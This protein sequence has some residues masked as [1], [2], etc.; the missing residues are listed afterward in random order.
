MD[1][2]FTRLIAKIL[3]RSLHYN[4]AGFEEREDEDYHHL[5]HLEYKIKL[6][7]NPREDDHQQLERLIA[8]MTAIIGTRTKE[9]D[10]E[11]ET[12]HKAVTALARD[13][14]KREW[15]RVKDRIYPP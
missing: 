5:T 2:Q 14:L 3:S 9:D 11:F 6:M 7:L 8:E 1:Q 10:I 13:V 12:C 4:V 15:D